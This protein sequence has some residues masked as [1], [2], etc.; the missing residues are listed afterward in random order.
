[1]RGGIFGHNLMAVL[2]FRTTQVFGSSKNFLSKVPPTFSMQSL[3]TVDY[4]SNVLRTVELRSDALRYFC[5]SC[6]D[7]YAHG[8]GFQLSMRP[9]MDPI[10]HTFLSMLAQAFRV[11][12]PPCQSWLQTIERPARYSSLSMLPTSRVQSLPDDFVRS[13]HVWF[14]INEVLGSSFTNGQIPEGQHCVRGTTAFFLSWIPAH[15][16]SI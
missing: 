11:V 15:P 12:M 1:M 10:T 9:T 4:L 2:R 16:S 3:S 13:H 5:T 8:L 7:V 14:R 6:T